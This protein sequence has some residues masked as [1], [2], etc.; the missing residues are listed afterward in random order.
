MKRFGIRL[1]ITLSTFIIG[2]TVAMVWILNRTPQ[3]PIIPVIESKIDN[4]APQAPPDATIYAEF[5][6][7]S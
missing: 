2:V 1:L 7:V 6:S 3:H 4:P 5:H